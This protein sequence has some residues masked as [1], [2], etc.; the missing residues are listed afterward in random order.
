MTFQKNSCAINK[1]SKLCSNDV[2]M[3]QQQQKENYFPLFYFDNEIMNEL[4]S[5]I[6]V[7]MKT[8]IED[9]LEK[10]EVRRKYAF[11]R[12]SVFSRGVHLKR[13]N[14]L[15]LKHNGNNFQWI[16]FITFLC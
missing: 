14:F 8:M 4:F 15:K 1:T 13:E 3:A 12:L 9:V 7:M 11:L 10:Y 16:T 5:I 6:Y 2:H